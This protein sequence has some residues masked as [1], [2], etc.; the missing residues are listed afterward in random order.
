MTEYG[1]CIFQILSQHIVWFV[2]ILPLEFCTVYDIDIPYLKKH[3]RIDALKNG[4][5]EYIL[6]VESF[7]NIL[8]PLLQIFEMII[9]TIMDIF[10]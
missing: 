7:R 8:I 10:F 9:C 6:L 1:V 4:Q 3:V 5:L 2:D